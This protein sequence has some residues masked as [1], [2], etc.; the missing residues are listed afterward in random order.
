MRRDERDRH[1]VEAPHHHRPAV[2]EVVRGGARRRAADQSVARLA[3]ELLST[4]LPGE[5][6][7]AAGLGTRNDDVVDSNLVPIRE[8]GGERAELDDTELAR[9]DAAERFL[10]AVSL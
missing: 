9:E 3:A 10:E 6:D 2:G 4:H 5:L 7:H 1:R 8:L